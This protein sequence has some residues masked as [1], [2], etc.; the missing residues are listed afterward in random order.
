[1]TRKLMAGLATALALA[2]SPVVAHP[3]MLA[4][5]P[6]EGA[7]VAAP[8]TIKLDFSEKL[9]ERLSGARLAR[10]DGQLPKTVI[11]FV[12]EGKS[13]QLAPAAPLAA[14]NYTVEWFGV[15]GDTHRVTGALHFTVR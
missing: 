5:T 12:G 3:K 7:A 11:S 14:G 13:M 8:A 2:G 6:A 10:A 9:I 15:A 4:S 1:M